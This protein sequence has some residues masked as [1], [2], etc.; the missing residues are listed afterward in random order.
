MTMQGRLLVRAV[1]VAAL[2]VLAG[3]EST[4]IPDIAHYRM[5]P[6][7]HVEPAGAPLFAEPFVID[8]FTADGVHSEQSILYQLT[9]NGPVKSYHYQLWNDPPAR[10]LQRRLIRR[11]RNE[12]V[13]PLVIDRLPVSAKALRVA[14]LVD[15]FE[16][17]RAEDESWSVAVRIELRVDRGDEA[18]PLLVETYEVVEATDGPSI[19]ATVRAFAR[20][21]DE[22]NTRFV[23]DLKELAAT[24]ER[25]GG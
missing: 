25:H 20:A 9:P 11:L 13:A 14:G 15:R 5:P 4:P 1:L 24:R 3:C 8:V 18:L 2:A 16:R 12:N 6:Q 19:Q 23:A 10:L 22:V 7:E 21:V 17:I